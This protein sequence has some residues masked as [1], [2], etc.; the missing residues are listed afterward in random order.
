MNSE[1]FKNKSM[2][3]FNIYWQDLTPECRK[4]LKA[5][6]GEEA[7]GDSVRPIVVLEKEC[8]EE[9]PSNGT[10]PK[11]LAKEKMV[12]FGCKACLEFLKVH[13]SYAN[14]EGLSIALENII[15]VEISDDI[16]ENTVFQFKPI[17]LNKR[18][19]RNLNEMVKSI[20]LS[21]AIKIATQYDYELKIVVWED[22]YARE[23]GLPFVVAWA[24]HI[25][26]YLDDDSDH[27]SANPGDAVVGSI[28]GYRGKYGCTELVAYKNNE[29][30]VLYHEER[31][32][33]FLSSDLFDILQLSCKEVV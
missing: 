31:D 9:T 29:E 4:R 7:K 24:E 15:P 21:Q 27:Y 26:E 20:L 14:E 11:A 2:K 22:S 6:L 13:N 18:E 5:F 30:L 33:D 28:D 17:L 12:V 25:A 3:Q 8:N 19:Y 32:D 10:K 1:W 23:E 16:C